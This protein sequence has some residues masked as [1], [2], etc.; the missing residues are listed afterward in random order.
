MAEENRT[1]TAIPWYRLE[2]K[3]ATPPELTHERFTDWNDWQDKGC[4]MLSLD[5]TMEPAAQGFE[6][7]EGGLKFYGQSGEIVNG[8]TS[9][10]FKVTNPHHYNEAFTLLDRVIDC[11][12]WGAGLANKLPQGAAYDP[13]VKDLALLGWLW[14]TGDGAPDG[15]PPASGH[16]W[17]PWGVGTN[18]WIFSNTTGTELRCHNS[19]GASI[20]IVIMGTITQGIK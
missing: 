19:T 9:T 14:Y 20:W 7:I 11:E 1:L 16:Y 13:D 3:T 4:R 10:L 2:D 5:G 8:A 17:R 12:I 18:V 6:D 15:G